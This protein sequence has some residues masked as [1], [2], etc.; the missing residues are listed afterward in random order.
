MSRKWE[1]QSYSWKELNS[2]SNL[3]ELGRGFS[4]E[5]L[6]ENAALQ[7]PFQ[8]FLDPEQNSTMPCQTSELLNSD[9]MNGF[10]L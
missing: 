2:F 7:A 8:H 1:P 4:L 6:E 3:S 9:V 10:C 5:P